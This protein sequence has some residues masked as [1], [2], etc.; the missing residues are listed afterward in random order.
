MLHLY[1]ALSSMLPSRG[2]EKGATATE[3]ALIIAFI[4]LVII[5]GLTLFGGRLES[6]WSNIANSIPSGTP[7]P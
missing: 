2:E 5:G 4:A 7:A 3:Y 6:I 1:V